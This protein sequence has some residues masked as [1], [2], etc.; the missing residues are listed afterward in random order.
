MPWC[1]NRPDLRPQEPRINTQDLWSEHLKSVAVLGAYAFQD[2]ASRFEKCGPLKSLFHSVFKN[3][4]FLC[5][6][7]V[8]NWAYYVNF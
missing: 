4:V 5:V 7:Y 8:C 6:V 2:L 1:I 3:R